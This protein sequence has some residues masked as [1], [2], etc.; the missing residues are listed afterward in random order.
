MKASV[1]EKERHGLEIAIAFVGDIAPAQKAAKL[2]NMKKSILG[3]QDVEFLWVLFLFFFS[4][5]HCPSSCRSYP[6]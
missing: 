2:H 5:T 6:C 1:Q 4:S 3:F